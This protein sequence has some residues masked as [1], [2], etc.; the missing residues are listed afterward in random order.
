MCYA[1]DAEPPIAPIA[2]AA[3]DHEDLVLTSADGTKFAAF[4][5]KA[6][7]PT[8]AGIVVLPDVRGLFHFYEELALRFAENGINAITIDYFGRTAGVGK[9]DAEFDWMTHVRQTK[10]AQISEDVGA[11]VQYL[12]WPA[13]GSCTSVFTVG[14]CFGGSNSWLQAA[15]GHGLAGAIGFYGR[16]GPSFADNSPGP[17]DHARDM[18]APILALMGGND[19]GIPKEDIA[20]LDKALTD[21]GVEHEVVT[22]DGAPH[23]FFDRMQEE[24]AEQSADAWKRVLEFIRKHTK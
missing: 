8:G 12:R 7:N 9:R 17:I 14:F 13:G 4:L 10:A 11:A 19:P 16:P 15:N 18:K 21:A 24:Y 20:A 2:G 5:A 23:S 1:F 22:Y 3:V 6:E